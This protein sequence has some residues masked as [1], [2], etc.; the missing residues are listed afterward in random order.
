MSGGHYQHTM[1]VTCRNWRPPDLRPAAASHYGLKS[2]KSEIKGSPKINVVSLWGNRAQNIYFTIFPFVAHSALIFVMGDAILW[3]LA[4]F[5]TWVRWLP[6]S[7]FN[8]LIIPSFVIIGENKNSKTNKFPKNYQ[9]KLK[10][11]WS[12]NRLH[13]TYSYVHKWYKIYT[14]WRLKL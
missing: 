2:R 13:T 1:Y 8:I 5:T 10:K 11:I 4:T 6:Q 12:S 7:H 3:P 14:S 9:I